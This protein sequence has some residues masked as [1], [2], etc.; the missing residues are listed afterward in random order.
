MSAKGAREEY[1]LNIERRHKQL[2]GSRASNYLDYLSELDIDIEP[3]TIRNSGIIC[4]IGP[5]SRSVE[6][7]VKLIENGMN[8][9]RL[10]FSHGTHEYHQET[11]GNIRRA[12]LIEW[13]H[14]VAIAL[15]TKGPEI[16]TGL[17]KGGGSAE[18]SLTKGQKLKVSTDKSM[19]DQCDSETIFVD[20]AN[21]VKMLESMVINPRPTRAETSDVA[22]AILDG[23][24]CV[25][26]SGMSMS[27][28][29]VPLT[30]FHSP[31]NFSFFT[32][33]FHSNTYAFL[34]T[35]CFDPSQALFY[36]LLPIQS[37]QHFF[38]SLCQQVR[39]LKAATQF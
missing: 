16:R 28:T 6:T 39:L 11:I 23:A 15:D 27:L 17:L 33:F 12:A 1:V 22:N 21:I 35:S 24:D 30:C 26:L 37:L 10:N 8:I 7:C 31:F 18:I 38:I 2:F 25:M 36:L 13:P 32:S 4:T 9:A 5:A 3:F 34:F 20:Y 29:S 14:A 19:Y